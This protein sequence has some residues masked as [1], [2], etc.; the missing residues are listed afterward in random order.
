MLKKHLKKSSIVDFLQVESILD[1]GIFSVGKSSLTSP[2]RKFYEQKKNKLLY[3]HVR[4]Q[5]CRLKH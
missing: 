4:R 2:A 3:N 5:A 1:I